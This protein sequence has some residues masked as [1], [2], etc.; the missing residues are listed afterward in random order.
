MTEAKLC[1][2]EEGNK[3]RCGEWK[4]VKEVGN[5]FFVFNGVIAFRTTQMILAQVV[6]ELLKQGTGKWWLKQGMEE[7]ESCYESAADLP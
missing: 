2:S 6:K 3:S 5:V 7:N 4:E 1:L